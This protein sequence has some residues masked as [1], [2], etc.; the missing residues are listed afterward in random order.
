MTKLTSRCVPDDV[1]KHD[2]N[3]EFQSLQNLLSSSVNEIEL[4]FK[5]MEE[6]DIS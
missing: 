4:Y 2:D 6:T 3:L 5:L 1:A